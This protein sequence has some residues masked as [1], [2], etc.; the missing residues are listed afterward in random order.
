MDIVAGER[1]CYNLLAFICL[2][3]EL[4]W[5]KNPMGNVHRDMFLSQMK[6]LNEVTQNY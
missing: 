3:M 4:N 2:K 5:R 6:V 1:L